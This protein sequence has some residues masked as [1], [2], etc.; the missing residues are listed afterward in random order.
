MNTT[1]KEVRML[2]DDIMSS[3]NQKWEKKYKE[4]KIEYKKELEKQKDDILIA[5]NKMIDR[6]S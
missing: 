6:I 1:N 2:S 3:V 4:F 5:I